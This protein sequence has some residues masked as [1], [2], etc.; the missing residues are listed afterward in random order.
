MV[1]ALLEAIEPQ[2][3]ATAVQF[4]RRS[5]VFEDALE[6]FRSLSRDGGA[7]CAHDASLPE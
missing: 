7:W 5:V 2:G 6:H 1:Q 4:F 3:I